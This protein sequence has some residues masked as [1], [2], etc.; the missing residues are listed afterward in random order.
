VPRYL[1]FMLGAVAV[2]GLLLA[3]AGATGRA[4]EPE[5]SAWAMRH[6]LHWFAGATGV[7]VLVGVWWLVAL[8][9]E[10]RA[11]FAGGD[12]Y[13]TVVLWIGSV[14]GLLALAV[15]V[16][17]LRRRWAAAPWVAVG[18]TVVTIAAMTLSRDAVRQAALGS[19]SALD[20]AIVAAQWLPI[21][22]F[23]ALL[24]WAVATVA[25]MVTRLRARP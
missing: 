18:A 14:A 8:P 7:N 19:E 16:V 22:L 17:G 15:S 21:G 1:H 25:W 20:G 11:L 5:L 13:A 4:K 6:G 12:A 2:A 23:V 24:V 9:P 3:A 10:T